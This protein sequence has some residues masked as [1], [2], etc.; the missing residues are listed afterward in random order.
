[1]TSLSRP[2]LR[3]ADTDFL[4]AERLRDDAI[5][6]LR[7]Q[8]IAKCQQ[9]VEKS[10]KAIA[11]DLSDR[12]IMAL[13]IGTSHPVDKLVTAILHA[14]GRSARRMIPSYIVNTL[15]RNYDDIDWIMG[16]APRGIVTE[17]NTEYPFFGSEGT[18]IA[19]ADPEVFSLDD[20][21]RAQKVA[22]T[23]LK[24]ARALASVTERSPS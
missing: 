7:C 19:P 20:V 11:Q 1:L 12:H 3:Q 9:T 17:R 8:V 10:I 6:A 14:P 21:K 15:D 18:L 24:Q 16:L 4:A 2:W 23:M 13:T 22:G 5:H